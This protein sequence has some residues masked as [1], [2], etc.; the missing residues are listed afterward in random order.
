MVRSVMVRRSVASVVVALTALGLGVALGGCPCGGARSISKTSEYV[1]LN[2]EQI[3]EPALGIVRS[4]QEEVGE[5]EAAL[6]VAGPPQRTLALDEVPALPTGG[7]SVEVLRYQQYVDGVLMAEYADP[8][9]VGDAPDIYRR[10]VRT[11]AASRCGSSEAVALWDYTLA[12]DERQPG[13]VVVERDL[14]YDGLGRTACCFCGNA[15]AQTLREEG[16]WFLDVL[17]DL[18]QDLSGAT[19]LDEEDVPPS[20]DDLRCSTC[21]YEKVV[22]YVME[23]YWGDS[24]APGCGDCGIRIE[25]KTVVIDGVLISDI[26]EAWFKRY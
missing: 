1:L 8:A 6:A 26:I 20:G 14:T 17:S 7:A 18:R 22:N 9:F 13:S 25:S 11:N 3:Q 2:L 16:E 4:I 10:I 24:E 21:A 15:T 19:L 23:D 5:I 12:E